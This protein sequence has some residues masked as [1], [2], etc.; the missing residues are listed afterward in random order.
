M[1]TA[2]QAHDAKD[3]FR[4]Y[5]AIR[6][7]APKQKYHQITVR[8]SVG[9]L[10]SPTQ[11]ADHLVQWYSQLYEDD[12]VDL[13]GNPFTWPFSQDEMLRGFLDFP[14]GKALA[15]QYAPTT[16]WKMSAQ[17][18]ADYLQPLVET[19]SQDA[20]LP[21]EWSA[22][23][24][25]FLPKPGT[26]GSNASELRPIALL[27][28]SGKVMLGILAQHIVEQAWT[29]LNCLPQFAYLP[30]RGCSS[31]IHR[32]A[33]H[34]HQVRLF[35]NDYKYPLHR[36]DND[37]PQPQLSGGITVSVDMSKA[38]DMVNRRLLFAS[39]SNL[40]IH[41]DIINMLKALYQHTTFSF[42]HRGET[43]TLRT[44][45]GIRQ[46]CKA[47]PTLWCCFAAQLLTDI[48][49][50]TSMEWLVDCI[51]MYADDMVMHQHFEN[52]DQL[53]TFIHTLDVLE[54]CGMKL[55]MN[56]SEVMC[57]F[58]G[59][60]SSKAQKRFVKR[61]KTGSFLIIPRCDQAPTLLKIVPDLKYLGIVLSYKQPELLTQKKRI[62]SGIRAQGQLARWLRCKNVLPISLKVKVWHQCVFPCL[63]YGILHVGVTPTSSALFQQECMKQLRRLYKEPV[64]MTRQSHVDFRLKH[65]LT[66]PVE[67]L[68][69]MTTR[70]WTETLR[71]RATL[72]ATDI[73]RRFEPDWFLQQLNTIHH[74]L[75][76]TTTTLTTTPTTSHHCSICK[77]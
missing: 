1:N 55:N 6:K 64:F 48:A 57:R 35:A 39:L 33:H 44:F 10:L 77:L 40:G 3:H 22:G 58:L 7:L 16:V 68:Y 5:A 42:S 67:L 29:R 34:C 66:H 54:K 17:P 24:L 50:Q 12:P 38:F 65:K 73:L 43:R 47:A 74:F 62:S 45:R 14:G 63:T 15:P 70:L 19:W 2:R 37:A 46:G 13:S 53:Q 59:P 21:P 69:K 75:H 52:I 49:L 20:A 27:E 60:G 51:T 4:L 41:D 23:T 71:I 18:I 11:A 9:E 31:A 36:Q 26:S 28:P 61:T 56:K 25:T 8:S 32:L 30:G 76:N 72:D